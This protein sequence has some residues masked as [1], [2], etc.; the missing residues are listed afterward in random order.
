MK[1]I[2]IFCLLAIAAFNANSQCNIDT[3]VQPRPGIFP[4][5][6]NLP[7]LI[8]NQPFDTTFQVT[9]PTIFD[10]VVNLGIT[11]Y[12]LTINVDS[13]E[14]DSIINLPAGLTWSRMPMRLP[15]GQHG[16]MKI[17][18]TPTGPTGY[19]SLGWWGTAWVTE[20]YGLGKKTVTG[21]MNRYAYVYYYLSVINAGDTCIPYNPYYNGIK[22]VNQALNANLIVSP[23]PS[24]GAF[25]V[26][27]SADGRTNAEIELI[28]VTGRSVYS[29]S[30]TLLE[31]QNNLNLDLR[32]NAKGLFTLMLHTAEGY[33]AKRLAVE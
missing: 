10:T 25:T 19:Y 20:P 22:E 24:N 5:Y 12:P 26:T 7:C 17:T 3:T 4:A 8:L 11:S 28:D 18:G 31:G 2:Y 6:Y 32:N 27:I 16:C 1:K 13:I 15:A 21:D 30:V 9:C 29:Q 14:L 33:A 23:N